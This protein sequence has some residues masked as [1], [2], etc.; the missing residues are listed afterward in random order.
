M[1]SSHSE[2]RAYR[3]S[4]SSTCTQRLRASCHH[5]L[6]LRRAIHG[7]TSFIQVF[8]CKSQRILNCSAFSREIGTLCRGRLMFEKVRQLHKWIEADHA[9]TVSHKVRERIHVV[10][11]E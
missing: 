4:Y 10:V 2:V 11:V 8:V 7:N 9:W 6:L 5:R 3:S 1:M